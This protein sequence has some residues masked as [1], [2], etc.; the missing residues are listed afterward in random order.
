MKKAHRHWSVSPDTLAVACIPV[1][2]IS[3]CSVFPKILGSREEESSRWW[4]TRGP[5]GVVGATTWRSGWRNTIGA[6]SVGRE[7]GLSLGR[8]VS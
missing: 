8:W 7:S 2:N 1:V 5:V 6:I 3:G 4:R